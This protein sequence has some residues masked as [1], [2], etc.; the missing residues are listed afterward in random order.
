MLLHYIEK[1]RAA[2]DLL[3]K[4]LNAAIMTHKMTF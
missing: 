3:Q 1:F 4:F 2:E